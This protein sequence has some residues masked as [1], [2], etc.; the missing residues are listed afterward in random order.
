[1][2]LISLQIGL[3]GFIIIFKEKMLYDSYLFHYIKYN[4][5]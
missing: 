3:K 2:K 1:M 5:I 4:E